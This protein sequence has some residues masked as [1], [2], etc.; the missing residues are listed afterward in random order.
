MNCGSHRDFHI[1]SIS[2]TIII[3]LSAQSVKSYT[4]MM[5]DAVVLSVVVVV[6]V[7]VNPN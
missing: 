4:H 5:G 1:V 6:V 2:E 7:V 3:K